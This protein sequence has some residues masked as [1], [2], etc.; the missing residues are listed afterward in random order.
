MK[1]HRRSR[2]GGYT[3]VEV[4][5]AMAI[6]AVGATGIMS[7]QT[8]A[9]RGNQEANEMGTATRIS[10]WW[11]DRLRLDALNW[12]IGGPGV[13][14]S[15]AMM[16]NTVY[17]NAMPAVGGTG[18]FVPTAPGALLAGNELGFNGNPAAGAGTVHFC[19]QAQLTWMYPGTALRADVRV[20]W[21]RR[22]WTSAAG[23]AACPAVPPR[24]D[25]HMVSASTILRYTAGGTP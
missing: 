8:A 3:L 21:R 13:L 12:R 10:E 19:T 4:M 7:L 5:M 9:T 15:P 23:A 6:L 11:L 1:A 2:T 25:F 20:F 18:W 22:Q 14:P 16:A 17:L 24:L